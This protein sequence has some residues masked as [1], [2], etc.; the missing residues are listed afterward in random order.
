MTLVSLS[1]PDS[2]TALQTRTLGE[3]QHKEMQASLIM[4]FD[5]KFNSDIP[6]AW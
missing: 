4:G 5:K 6:R 3:K 1:L 2:P